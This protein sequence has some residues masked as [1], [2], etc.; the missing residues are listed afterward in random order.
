M[1]PFSSL[2]ATLTQIYPP[3]PTFTE[4]DVPANSQSGRVFIVR[5]G[6]AGIGLELT[7]ILYAAGATVYIASRSKDK[8]EAAIRNIT[9]NLP[10]HTTISERRRLQNRNAQR[11]FR[12]FFSIT[13]L[14]FPVSRFHLDPAT[15]PI[16]TILTVIFIDTQRDEQQK[17]QYCA[18]R[19]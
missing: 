16:R 14:S 15:K 7:K 19:D 12:L 17:S 13:L 8:V 4:A 5:G 9:T 10:S 11:R 2:R 18:S 6:N 1:A 3:K